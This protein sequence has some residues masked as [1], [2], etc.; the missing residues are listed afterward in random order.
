MAIL[1]YRN[2]NSLKLYPFSDTA[3]TRDS[4]DVYT[5][6]N[7]FIVDALFYLKE[8]NR[9]KVQLKRLQNTGTDLIFTFADHD[10]PTHEYGT[11]TASYASVLSGLVTFTNANIELK[12]VFFEEGTSSVLAVGVFDYTF[13]D[14]PFVEKQIKKKITTV[15][16]ISIDNGLSWI[17]TDDIELSAGANIQLSEE[18]ERLIIDVIPGSGTGLYNICDD[19]SDSVIRSINGVSPDEFGNF[20]INKEKCYLIKKIT[21]GLNISNSC[22]PKCDPDDFVNFGHYLNRIN[23]LMLQ[24]GTKANETQTILA[25]II[26]DF[27]TNTTGDT[28]KTRKCPCINVIQSQVVPFSGNAGVPINYNIYVYVKNP[29]DTEITYDLSLGSTSGTFSNV[30]LSTKDGSYRF[31]S[32]T[33]TGIKLCPLSQHVMFA[34]LRTPTAGATVTATFSYTPVIN[35]AC[36]SSIIKTT[37]IPTTSSPPTSC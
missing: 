35:D 4:T 26:E 16:R 17:M 10:Q 14:L 11:V 28:V 33:L 5:L 7:S 13:L 15:D 24:V 31:A 32:T 34:N 9:N 8:S 23:D 18:E 20:R 2:E 21:N 1:E 25:A 36:S 3:N 12:I 27:V 30:V 22:D 29:S 37:T 6:P 19:L